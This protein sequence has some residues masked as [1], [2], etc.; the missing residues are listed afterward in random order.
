VRDWQYVEYRYLNHPSHAYQCYFI[1]DNKDPEFLVFVVLKK[2]EDSW[3]LLDII[4]SRSNFKRAIVELNGLITQWDN[5]R[6][7]KCWITSGWHQA[8]VT[9]TAEVNDLKIEIPCH[10]WTLGP[11]AELL[12][13]KWWLT[14][15]DMDFI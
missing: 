6:G 7:I 12:Y 5:L 2:H 13:G 4:G 10:S 1:A 3:L 11:S 14:A 15:G 9:E 8:L